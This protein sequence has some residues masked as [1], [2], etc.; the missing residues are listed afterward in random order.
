MIKHNTNRQRIHVRREAGSGNLKIE[1]TPNE[2]NDPIKL[3]FHLITRDGVKV[4]VQGKYHVVE[5]HGT[6]RPEVNIINDYHAL[7]R[8]EEARRKKK[9][10]SAD[11]DESST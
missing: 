11:S 3:R 6:Q 9:K 5:A 8:R 7:Y 10:H 2:T 1:I 4:P